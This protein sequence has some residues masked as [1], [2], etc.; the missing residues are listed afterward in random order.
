MD[1]TEDY[2]GHKAKEIVHYTTTSKHFDLAMQFVGPDDT[3]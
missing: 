2:T 3:K 1:R